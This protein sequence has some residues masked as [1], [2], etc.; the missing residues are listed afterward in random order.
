MHPE[1]KKF[2][3]A[4]S[5][6]VVYFQD[7]KLYVMLKDNTYH[8]IAVYDD[9]NNLQHSVGGKNWNEAEMLKLIKLKAFL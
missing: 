4:S 9:D 6:G 5:E 3:E 2:Y 1:I 8:T 7:Y